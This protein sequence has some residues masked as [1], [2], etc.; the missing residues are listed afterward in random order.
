M[1]L[2]DINGFDHRPYVVSGRISP[3]LVVNQNWIFWGA[4]GLVYGVP[5]GF[6]YNLASRP[7]FSEF[8]IPKL[9]RTQR[10]SAIHGY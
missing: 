3:N 6:V 8:Y 7:A 5:P 1:F 2:S 9:G 4:D 10:P